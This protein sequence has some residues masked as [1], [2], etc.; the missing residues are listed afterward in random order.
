MQRPVHTTWDLLP[1]P[2]AGDILQGSDTATSLLKWKKKRL[3]DSESTF[4]FWV[5]LHLKHHS[6]LTY[7]VCTRLICIHLT[8]LPKLAPKHFHLFN[9][10]IIAFLRQTFMRYVLFTRR[11]KC[12]GAEQWNGSALCWGSSFSVWEMDTQADSPSTACWAFPGWRKPRGPWERRGGAPNSAWN[13]LG[14]SQE[15]LLENLSRV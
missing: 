1:S 7:T 3:S 9:H 12:R 13:G 4:N 2:S 11:S 14:D 10:L 5:Y 8:V 6:A 15:R